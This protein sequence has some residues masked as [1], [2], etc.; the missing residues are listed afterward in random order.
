VVGLKVK[1]HLAALARSRRWEVERRGRDRYRRTL[2]RVD[3]GGQ[4]VGQVLIQEG[5]RP[6]P[7]R[8]TGGSRGSASMIIPSEEA[9]A[10]DEAVPLP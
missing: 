9:A 7:A 3:V 2:A 8:R 5:A 6:A 1:E 4:D 10:V